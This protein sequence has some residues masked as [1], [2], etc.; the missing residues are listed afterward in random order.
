MPPHGGAVSQLF[1]IFKGRFSM[2]SS[3]KR[4]EGA[5]YDE[6]EQI[7]LRTPCEFNGRSSIRPQVEIIKAI[8]KTTLDN[9]TQ[10]VCRQSRYN[11]QSLPLPGKRHDVSANFLER[12]QGT[13]R[14]RLDRDSFSRWIPQDPKQVSST[15]SSWI[16]HPRRGK[17]I[18]GG[19]RGRLYKE[20]NNLY[21]SGTKMG[22]LICA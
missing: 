12:D 13:Q 22:E 5:I 10:R 8:H 20:L 21:L 1:L 9:V 14:D 7:H 2:S 15:R 11:N 3:A 6:A 17:A 18:L 4:D 16:L 19:Y